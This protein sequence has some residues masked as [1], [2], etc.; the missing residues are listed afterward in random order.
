MQ[1]ECVERLL[2]DNIAFKSSMDKSHDQM[3]MW[4]EACGGSCSAAGLVTLSLAGC[5]PLTRSPFLFFPV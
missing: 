3:G 1:M 4:H 2:R 5:F